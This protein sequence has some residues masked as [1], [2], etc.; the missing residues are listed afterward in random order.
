VRFIMK[1][2]WAGF[3]KK[4]GIEDT[5]PVNL[6]LHERYRPEGLGMAGA[7]IGA[8]L[9]AKHIHPVAGVPA[10]ALGALA[11]IIAGINLLPKEKQVARARAITKKTGPLNADQY[12][13][14]EK[15]S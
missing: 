5:D 10:G 4:A 1:D 14:M 11:G 12:K 3:E 2:F 13:K 7:G 8:Y 15:K 6:K 9:G